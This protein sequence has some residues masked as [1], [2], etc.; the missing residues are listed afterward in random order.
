[1][2]PAGFV[3]AS[4]LNRWK[5]ASGENTKKSRKKDQV[6][7]AVRS[8]KT[9]RERRPPQSERS[10]I[11]AVR[12]PA[13]RPRD[14][15]YTFGR[16]KRA[17]RN[18]ERRSGDGSEIGGTGATILRLRPAPLVRLIERQ[19]I[20]TEEMR[21]ADDITTAFHAQAGEVSVLTNSPAAAG[22]QP[23]VGAGNVT[24]PG[25]STA[26]HV[27]TFADGTGKVLADGGAPVGAANTITPSMLANAAVAFGVGMLNGTLVASIAGNALTIAVKTLAGVD[28]SPADPVFFLFR[29][30][31]AGYAVIEQTAALS[32]TVP[33][34][35]TLGTIN[36]QA[37]RI[38]VGV[39]N[40]GGTAVLGIYNSLS[41]QAGVPSN[42][43][44]LPWDETSAAN[45]TG[46]TSGSTGAQ[47]WYTASTLSSKV[48]RILGH[49]E[50]TQATAGTWATSPGK[51]QLFGPGV[52]R[53]GDGGSHANFSQNSLVNFSSTSF[54]ALTGMVVSISLAAPCNLVWVDSFGMVNV[55]NNT[56]ASLGLSRGTTNNTNMI[57][58]VA[59]SGNVQGSSQIY[60]MP[61][62]TYDLPN[63][64]GSISYSLQGKSSAG[65]SCTWG[66][67]GFVT[68]SAREIHI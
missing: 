42:P 47:L 8:L 40:N 26:G 30:A 66:A 21:A 12:Q 51:V 41:F 64:S 15:A 33:S 61:V 31:S 50:S 63:T 3:T 13:R 36:G 57:G 28:P 59:T 60:T 39:F 49:V 53:P 35:A 62:N 23:P 9:E 7:M 5:R 46:V 22:Y 56:N 6:I 14:N 27:A 54:V 44:V 29:D 32:I 25:S 2:R 16:L 24:G 4:I 1:M 52:R 37:N 18:A 38:W 48:F 45:G 20:G 19:R 67:S 10:T 58:A 55:A 68:L 34:G 43:S 17:I 11:S 65:S